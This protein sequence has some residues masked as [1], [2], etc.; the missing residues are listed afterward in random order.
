[1]KDSVIK[2]T[3]AIWLPVILVAVPVTIF[4]LSTID[5][6]ELVN[7]RNRSKDSVAGQVNVVL[8]DFSYVIQDLYAIQDD[9]TL[10][11]LWGRESGVIPGPLSELGRHFLT[12]VRHRHFYD[13]IRLLDENGMELVRVNYNSGIPYIVAP[14]E[15]QNKKGRYYFEEAF[16]LEKGEVYVSPF[17]L[18]IEHSQIEIPHKPMLRFAIPVF[19]S[20]GRKRGVILLNYLGEKIRNSF[21]SVADHTQ[22]YRSMLLNSDGYWLKGPDPEAEWGFMFEDRR[23]KTFAK[24][25]PGAWKKIIGDESSQFVSEEGL[26]TSLRID[27][28][29]DVWDNRSFRKQSPNAYRKMAEAGESWFI[30]Q[31]IPGPVLYALRD[32]R[33]AGAALVLVLLAITWLFGSFAIARTA[34]SRRRAEDTARERERMYQALFEN[35]L[36][37]ILVMTRDGSIIAANPS[38]CSMFGYSQTE[39][40]HLGRKGIVDVSSPQAAAALEEHTQTGSFRGELSFLRGNGGIFAGEASCRMYRSK[41]GEQMTSMIV[42]DI[43]RRKEIETDL[44]RNR[45]QLAA[46]MRMARTGHWEYD[47]LTDTFSFNDQFYQIFKATAD[48]IGGYTMSLVEYTGRFCHPDDAPVVAAE[49]Q[50]ALE[51]V[52]PDQSRWL[53]HRFFYA[54]GGVGYLEVRY[55]LEKDTQGCTVKLFGV[56]QDITGRK[57][58]E[59]ELRLANET[60]EERVQF[61]TNEIEKLNRQLVLQDKMASVG[62]LAA[63]IAHELYNPINFVRTNFAALSD[64][65]GDLS[66]ML[67]DYREME[68]GGG[69]AAQSG[70]INAI[71]ER[72]QA[73]QLDF[74]LEDIPILFQESELG[75]ESIIRVVESLLV[76]SRA[77][78]SAG[79]TEFNINKSVEDTLVI[80]KNTYKYHAEVRTELEN[81]PLVSCLPEQI[82]QV[83]L[84]LIVNSAQA[85]EGASGGEKGLISIKTWQENGYVHCRII[86]N[87]PG[88]PEEIRSRVFE[89]FFTTKE[90]GKGT[91]L[92]LSISYDIIVNNHKGAMSVDCPDSGGTAFTF[93]LPVRQPTTG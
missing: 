69:Q 5:R 74:I 78:Q 13:Q 34:L 71:R 45:E 17:D 42:R 72:E 36:D 1:M 37:A 57:Q 53:E 29:L 67:S 59:E 88:I 63:G 35:S 87:G 85:V 23:E 27:P 75:F 91:G 84:N 51:A 10:E 12:I 64:Y 33:R 89:P 66:T 65:F 52:G 19:D 32:K 26:V 81:L 30:V 2:L 61:R 21:F 41:Q 73:L 46:A 16:A 82:N 50:S 60:L 6:A 68:E 62:L 20:H 43:S 40:C 80:A 90:A 9:E 18:N 49:I 77:D 86:D 56:N 58:I 14:G 55:F 4:I 3:F 47:A 15:L 24:I 48:G 93:S 44:R 11:N 38:S 22:G 31:I 79:F 25:F 54:D 70:R 83:L 76:F 28:L 92:G 8:Q 7:Y 39:L